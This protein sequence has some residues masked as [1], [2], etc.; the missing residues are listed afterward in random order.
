[1]WLRRDTVQW[2][3]YMPLWARCAQMLVNY[4]RQTVDKHEHRQTFT[5]SFL[6]DWRY[7]S[8]AAAGADGAFEVGG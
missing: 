4:S 7:I 3:T 8:R 2:F 1:M 5:D 6:H